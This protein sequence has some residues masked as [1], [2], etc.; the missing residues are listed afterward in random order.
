MTVPEM[1]PEVNRGGGRAGEGGQESRIRLVFKP[2]SEM[3]PEV[4][5]SGRGVVWLERVAWGEVTP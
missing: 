4:N 3:C 2:F 5:P 1:C